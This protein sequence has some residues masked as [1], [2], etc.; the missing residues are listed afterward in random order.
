MA[1]RRERHVNG[2]IGIRLDRRRQFRSVGKLG[3]RAVAG[4]HEKSDLHRMPAHISKGEYMID[5]RRIVG[6]RPHGKSRRGAVRRHKP[7]NL[8]TAPD[9]HKKPA[10]ASRVVSVRHRGQCRH[11][12]SKQNL[13]KGSRGFHAK[14]P[15]RQSG[16]NT[17]SIGGKRASE[18]TPRKLKTNPK[19]THGQCFSAPPQ[20]RVFFLGAA[21][22]A[23]P[24]DK[25][26]SSNSHR[27]NHGDHRIFL[28]RPI[29][30]TRN[31]QRGVLTPRLELRRGP[32]IRWLIQ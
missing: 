1:G 3:A 4:R 8:P 30:W 9:H 24:S 17:P 20:N 32:I 22:S 11:Y 5:R 16:D 21:R 15:L 27:V 2:H 26:P 31:S 10:R 19:T 13:S 25:N 29:H 28:S 7:G 23:A 6:D 12:E 14:Q 18:A